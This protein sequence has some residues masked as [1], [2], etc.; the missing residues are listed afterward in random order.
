MKTRRFDFNFTPL[1]TQVSILSDGSIP[2]SQDY[3]AN[4]G[5]YTPDYRLTPLVLQPVVSVIDKDGIIPAGK[6]NYELANIRWYEIVDGQRTL[7]TTGGSYEVMAS[8]EDAGRLTVKKNVRPL[9]PVTLEYYAEYPDQRTGQILVLRGSYLLNCRSSASALR[10]EADCAAQRVYNPLVENPTRNLGYYFP[11]HF[12]LFS[13]DRRV[14]LVNGRHRFVCEKLREDGTWSEIGTDTVMDYDVAYGASTSTRY[15][16]IVYPESMGDEMKLRIRCKIDPEGDVA[17]MPVSDSMPTAYVSIV[18]RICAFETEIT[19]LPYNIPGDCTAI[20]PRGVVRTNKRILE[21]YD[22]VLLP[23]WHV[24]RNR[25]SGSLVYTQVAHGVNPVIPTDA[26]DREI[27]AV[28][29]FDA[30]DRGAT[31]AW[32]DA[33][34]A[35][36]L[37]K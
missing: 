14:V 27:G 5:E 9:Q 15:F 35:V 31:A 1:Q 34:G 17:A 28:V 37:L 19:D 16:V 29:G 23:T 3:D 2:D 21:D 20:Y 10:V 6:V 26:F 36:I 24:A 18:R 8:G 12:T 32:T 25:V 13:G 11:L 7:I 22:K 33:S 30:Q 4:L